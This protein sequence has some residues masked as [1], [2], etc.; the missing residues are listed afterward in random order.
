MKRRWLHV[1]F[2][3][4]QLCVVQVLANF[5][6]IDF[7]LLNPVCLSHCVPLRPHG[8]SS[9]WLSLWLH[10]DPP[11]RLQNARHLC[12]NYMY[13]YLVS[14]TRSNPPPGNFIERLY[15]KMQAL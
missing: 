5:N 14:N 12:P 10:V 13:M 3:K 6:L 11:D 1:K 8:L 9:M 2:G 15:V 4:F 7:S